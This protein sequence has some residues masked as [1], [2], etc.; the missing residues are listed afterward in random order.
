MLRSLIKI[1]RA[2]LAQI[3]MEKADKYAKLA[4]KHANMARLQII[5]VPISEEVIRFR[6]SDYDPDRAEK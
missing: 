1:L 5:S 3:D 4:E 6:H 2:S